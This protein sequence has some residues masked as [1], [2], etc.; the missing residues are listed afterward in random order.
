MTDGG[1]QEES[2]RDL[3]ARVIDNTKAY[4]RAEANLLKQTASL[5][6]T[7]AIPAAVLIVIAILLTQAALT[8]LI[9]ALGWAL[10]SWL[11]VPA[12]LALAAVITLALAGLLVWLAV[13][14]LT[15]PKP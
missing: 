12:G 7:R 4:L 9:A 2:L 1:G 14:K 3:V 6:A 10:A 13:R 11:G 8:V 5:W 15:G